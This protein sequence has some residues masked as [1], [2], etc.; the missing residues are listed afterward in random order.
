VR[1]HLRATTSPTLIPGRVAARELRQLAD[2]LDAGH[3][4]LYSSDYPHDHGSDALDNL[5]GVLTDEER[6]AV[7]TKNAA[8]FFDIL[9]P[10]PS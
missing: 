1:E 9:L 5:F 10:A 4:L 8:A 6:D 7:L 3:M 2:M